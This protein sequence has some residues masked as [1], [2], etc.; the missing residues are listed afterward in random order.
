M[1]CL[2]TPSSDESDLMFSESDYELRQRNGHLP[3][4]FH[5]ASKIFLDLSTFYSSLSSMGV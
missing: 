1:F 3:N 4:Y 2:I 5:K